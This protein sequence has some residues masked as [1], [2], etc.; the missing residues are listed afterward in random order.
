MHQEG[1]HHPR[2]PRPHL[3][4]WSLRHRRHPHRSSLAS[5]SEG[6]RRTMR[7]PRPRSRCSHHPH[8]R[9]PSG[10]RR[11]RRR[12][13]RRRPPPCLSARARPARPPSRRDWAP[14]WQRPAPA[15]P[16]PPPLPPLLPP[17]CPSSS[18]RASSSPRP[19]AVPGRPRASAPA[20][21]R[22]APTQKEGGERGGL[23]RA[24]RI[25]NTKTCHGQA[26]RRATKGEAE[27]SAV[28]PHDMACMRVSPAAQQ[29][30]H[31]AH[32]CHAQEHPACTLQD[33]TVPLP[34]PAP[35]L[36]H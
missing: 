17:P 36:V 33:C 12:R 30:A 25:E 29:P 26:D 9:R 6:L 19:D 21:P 28:Q 20:P 11:R 3:Q 10:S 27:P 24:G 15:M 2:L 14:P 4:Q 34:A 32:K 35:A 13:R 18:L 16:P 8:H 1:T 23:R 5:C 22:T 31:T 7:R